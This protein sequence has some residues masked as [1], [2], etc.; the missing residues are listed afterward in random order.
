MHRASAYFALGDKGR[1]LDDYNA[2]IKSAP[3][4]A[5]LY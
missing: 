4:N 5:A 3:G 2:A 1:V